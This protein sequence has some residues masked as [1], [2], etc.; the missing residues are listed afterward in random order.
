MGNSD[1]LS[2]LGNVFEYVQN[3]FETTLSEDGNDGEADE[4]S[5]FK[6]QTRKSQQSLGSCDAE[7]ATG[8]SPREVSLR[9]FSG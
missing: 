4:Y 9:D 1:G 5:S 7:V 6:D 2:R 3:T 8:K